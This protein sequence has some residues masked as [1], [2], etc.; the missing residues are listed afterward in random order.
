[1]N[2]S[3]VAVACTL[4][5]FYLKHYQRKPHRQTGISRM[6]NKPIKIKRR[7]FLRDGLRT[8]STLFIGGIVALTTTR[9]RAK[10]TVWQLD[11]NKCVQ[12]ERCSTE[13]VLTLSAVKCV[14]A[15][16]VCGYCK[17]CGGYHRPGS[18][19]QDTAAENQL[20][21]TGAIKRTYVE[22]PY[23]EYTITEEKCTGCGKCVKG[24]SS[25]GNGSLFLQV[26][27]DRCLNCNECS[28]AKG[29]PSEAYQRVPV[30]KPYI[31]KGKQGQ[32]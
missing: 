13:C 1:M 14:H 22:N 18:K 21:P 9:L 12:C 32:A 27:H 5:V 10:N 20:C 25:F 31:L 30:D 8:I 4:I 11:P 3:A 28:I 26:R 17:L 24:C 7:D 16:D 23:Y 15:F 29:C 19:K 2:G 6:N